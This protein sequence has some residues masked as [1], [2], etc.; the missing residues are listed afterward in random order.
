MKRIKG[1]GSFREKAGSVIFGGLNL[2]CG[3]AIWAVC[4]GVS[5]FRT[6]PRG[7]DGVTAGRKIAHGREN[8]LVLRRRLA[9]CPTVAWPS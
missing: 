7:E 8:V 1:G 6:T 9:V 2:A 3:T 4:R 5:S